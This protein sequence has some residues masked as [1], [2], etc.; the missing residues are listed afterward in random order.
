MRAV[1]GG[2]RRAPKL[3]PNSSAGTNVMTRSR[4]A[5]GRSGCVGLVC[6][7]PY[8]VLASADVDTMVCDSAVAAFRSK[9]SSTFRMGR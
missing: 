9:P 6:V 8:A 5:S 1:R 3:T 7:R 4:S 2:R